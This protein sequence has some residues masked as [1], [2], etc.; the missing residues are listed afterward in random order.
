MLQNYLITTLRILSRRRGSFLFNVTGLTLGISASVILF[1]LVDFQT[2]FDTFNTNFQRIYRVTTVSDGSSEKDYQPG[3]PAVLPGALAEE[4]PEAEK[5]TFTSYRSGATILIPKADGTYSKFEEPKGVVFAQ[6]SFF[7]LF[8]RST[9]EGDPQKTLASPNQAV[10]ST[11][12]AEKYFR[13][14]DPIGKIIHYDTLDFVVG[15]VIPDYADNTDFPFNLMF[16]QIT[17]ARGLEDEGWGS[18]SSNNQCYFLLKEGIDIK[19]LEARMPDFVTKYLG[20]DNWDHQTFLFQP[21]SDLHFDTRFSNYNYSSVSKGVIAMLSVIGIFLIITACINFINLT[22]AEAIK[23]SKEV[24]IRKTLGGSRSQLVRQ[25][26]GETATITLLAMVL[27]LGVVQV[28]LQ[29]LNPFLH[30]SLSLDLTGNMSLVAYL[31]GVF[32]IVSLLSGLYPAFTLS[33]Y[34]PVTALKNQLDNKRSSG[35]WM[36]KSLVAFQFIISQFFI[37][38]T[39]VLIAQ[40]RYFQQKDLGLP[41]DAV[42]NVPIPGQTDDQKKKTLA[43]EFARIQGV[44]QVSLSSTPPSSGSTSATSFTVDGIDQNF[45]TQVKQVD[46]EY[47]K[48]YKLEL[49]AGTTL[50]PS[51][52]PVA[53]VVNERLVK[54]MGF[55]QPEEILGRNLTMWGRTLPVVGVVK[56]FHATSLRREIEPIVLRSEIRGYYTAS[57][58]INSPD[59]ARMVSKIKQTWESFFP[60]SVFDYTF[61]DERIKQFYEGEQKMSILLG[62]FTT[63]AIFIGCLGLFGLATYMINQKTKEIGVRKV[64]GASVSGIMLIFSREYVQLVAIGFIVAAPLSWYV[65]NG[66]LDTFAY[67]ITIGWW[68]FVLG[69]LTTFLIAM[70]TVG[71]R[72]YRAAV[73]NPINSLRYE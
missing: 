24:G 36:R 67:K 57:L 60:E 64:L 15:A 21:M 66:W 4:F 63:L 52:T 70:C 9:V 1:L 55:Q 32:L 35:F 65:M 23:R 50:P 25:F 72:S 5:I 34:N 17:I 30:Q 10:V 73:R 43:I 29:F 47:T 3:V 51:D 19:Q 40:M 59:V 68:V 31:V 8:D 45:T 53:H 18:I 48:L 27:S 41:K 28:S 61:L 58:K 12:L 20:D 33:G 2:S 49:L 62:I 7:D 6:P 71:Y 39:I 44:E 56:D 13:G 54:L 22:T 14:Q 46:A 26:L 42:I 37:F 38:G 11:S 69:V 16:S